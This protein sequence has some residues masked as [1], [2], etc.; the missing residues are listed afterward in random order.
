[1][2]GSSAP[3]QGTEAWHALRKKRMTGSKPANI[4]FEVKSREDWNRVHEEFFGDKKPPPFSEEALARMDY[5]SR[6]E[7]VAAMCL[8]RNLPGSLFFECPLIPHPKFN[9]MAASPDGFMVQYSTDDKGN[10]RPELKV[11]KRYNVEIKCPLFELLEHPAEMK[12]KMAKKKA[13][14][15]YYMPQIHFEMVMN[16]VRT[17]LFCMY[18]PVRTH[19]WRIEFSDEYWHMTVDILKAFKDRCCTWT[20]LQ[21][22]IKRWVR[23]S[24]KFAAKNKIWKIIEEK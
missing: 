18:T 13:P 22:K 7:D 20:Y 9:W 3:E 23:V 16:R 17:T 8:L 15:Y 1:M 10:I 24:Q 12:K 5:G 4:M 6:T 14:P 11:E 19:V 21:D 2:Q